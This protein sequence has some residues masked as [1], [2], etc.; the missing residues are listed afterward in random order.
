MNETTRK[1]FQEVIKKAGY[2]YYYKNPIGKCGGVA[3]LIKH[4]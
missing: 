2:I 4:Y 1:R 3:L